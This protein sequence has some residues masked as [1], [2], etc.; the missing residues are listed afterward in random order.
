MQPNLDVL[1]FGSG[2]EQR[3]RIADLGGHGVADAFLLA[4]FGE[5]GQSGSA[6]RDPDGDADASLVREDARSPASSARNR[7][8]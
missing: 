6:E 7:A 4:A 2:L 3:E 1:D 8:L 5:C